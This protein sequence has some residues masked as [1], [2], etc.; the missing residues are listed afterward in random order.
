M[1][2]FYQKYFKRIF[3]TLFSIFILSLSWPA[4]LIIA[5][6]IKI[7]SPGPV[8]FKQQRIGKNNQT[9]TL[10]K[11]RTMVKNAQQL[12]KKHLDLNEADGPVFKIKND[13]R[14]VNKFT[15]CLAHSGIDELPNFLN[16]LKGEMSLVGPRPLPVAENEKIK[17][18]IK[19]IRNSVIPGIT[20]LW[21][22]QG[23]HNLN[24]KTW[25]K[26]DKKYIENISFKTDIT[27]LFK[28]LLII[29]KALY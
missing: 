29:L 7:S 23:A 9:F 25:M 2:S 21:V 28:T 20:S 8:F 1:I 6:L 27:I 24:F 22:V 18:Q 14:F 4:F 15:K 3:D 11:F 12:Q 5:L 16:V 26:L 13:P 10:Y 19:K 17:P